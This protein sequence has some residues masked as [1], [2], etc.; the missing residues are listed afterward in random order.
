MLGLLA[1]GL[2]LGMGIGG[3]FLEAEGAEQ[4]RNELKNA[5]YKYLPNIGG[6]EGQ[7]FT[8]ASQYQPQAEK[9]ARETALSDQSI[10]QQMQE[11]AIPGFG[12]MRSDA[13]NALFPLLSGNLPP[14]VYNSFL[15]SG[16]AE[17]GNLG[18]S[19]S[20]MSFLQQGLF[21]AQGQ[22]GAMRLGYGLLPRLMATMPMPRTPGTAGFMNQL[23][24]PSQR[25]QTEMNLR[26]QNLGL[27]R[28]RA[29]MPT[30]GEM[31]GKFLSQTG[32]ML[33]GAGIMGAMAGGGSSSIS[34]P[35]LSGSG[36]MTPSGEITSMGQETIGSIVPAAFA[37]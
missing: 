13:A 28:E 12:K 7:Y 33:T 4:R 30:S 27:M 11:N 5:T 22:L 32:G 37:Y 36:S 29:T 3:T 23:L 10:L 21:G 9:L 16:A 26:A 2:G 6:A 31:W 8:D 1:G 19:G 25:V 34:M 20:G 18:L 15:K 24:T 17:A 35:S 14:S